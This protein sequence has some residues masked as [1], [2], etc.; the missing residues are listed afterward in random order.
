MKESGNMN[1]ASQY[2]TTRLQLPRIDI[3]GFGSVVVLTD[4][5]VQA[6][7]PVWEGNE[8]PHI[9]V[10]RFRLRHPNGILWSYRNSGRSADVMRI[11]FV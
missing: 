5:I 8:I 1:N 9:K 7:Q 10:F 3:E 11:E 2:S 6:E 4:S